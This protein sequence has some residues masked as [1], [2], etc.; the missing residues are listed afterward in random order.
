VGA[1][2]GV[3]GVKGAGPLT[4]WGELVQIHDER[5]A[6]QSSPDDVPVIDIH[7][8]YRDPMLRCGRSASTAVS[9]P[10]CA[11]AENPALSVDR[12]LLGTSK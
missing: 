2:D 5:G 9:R 10:V 3:E 8:L 1:G 6:I 7:S 11:A 12:K 4:D